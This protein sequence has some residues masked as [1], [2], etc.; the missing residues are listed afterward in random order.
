ML[1]EDTSPDSYWIRV[2]QSKIQ[3]NRKHFVLYPDFSGG[4]DTY[5]E[6]KGGESQHQPPSEIPELKP[7]NE[8]SPVEN[9][10][11][12]DSK[13][14]IYEQQIDVIPI[15]NEVPVGSGG[16]RALHKCSRC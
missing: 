16:T 10:K 2:K 4:C 9:V 13:H 8:M 1:R 14:F 6:G 7:E 5:D 12:I 15:E 3:K 11:P